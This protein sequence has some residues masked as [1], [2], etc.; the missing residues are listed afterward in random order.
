MHHRPAPVH[1]VLCERPALLD[2]LLLL[3]HGCDV[4]ETEACAFCV[5]RVFE[6]GTEEERPA[7][8]GGTKHKLLVLVTR[9]ICRC[10]DDK[11]AGVTDGADGIGQ[12][13]IL[14]FEVCKLAQMEGAHG[15]ASCATALHPAC[16]GTQACACVT[17]L[18]C[19]GS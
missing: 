7:V 10:L 14:P 17:E 16:K 8:L 3:R 4:G 12:D 2:N 5:G 1:L 13:L 19:P 9:S 18:D 15:K 6:P 11:S